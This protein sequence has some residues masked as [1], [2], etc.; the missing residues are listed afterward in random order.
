M[1]K[2]E[3]GYDMRLCVK[4]LVILF[5]VAVVYRC[6]NRLLQLLL[7]IPF[8]RRLIVKREIRKFE[9]MNDLS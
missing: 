1:G 5:G 8:V 2:D 9:H 4:V 6:K 3:S 7:F